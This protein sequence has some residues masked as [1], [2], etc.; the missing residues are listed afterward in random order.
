MAR[1]LF[2]SGLGYFCGWVRNLIYALLLLVLVPW[3]LWR[4]WTTG[5]YR[6]G[7]RDKLLGCDALRHRSNNSA[8]RVWLHGV[9]V[10]EIQ[11]LAPLI[12][13]LREEH[14]AIDFVVSTT[15][16]TGMELAQ[17]LFGELGDV[18]LIYFPLDFTWS[19][20]RTMRRVDADLLVLGELEVWPNLLQ[21]AQRHQ[22]LIV[23]VNGRLSAR[24]FRGY[25][26]LRWIVRPMFARLTCVL[27]QT[28]EYADRF[29]ACGVARD[30]VSVTGS[31]KFDHVR[32]D[33]NC[34]QV[35]QLA[36]LVGIRPE[37]CVWVLGSSQGPEESVCCAAW[38]K[39]RKNFP[40]LKL[41][42]VPRHRERF[43]EVF[44][45]LEQFRSSDPQTKVRVLRRSQISQPVRGDTWDVLLVDTIGE[46]RWWWGLARLALVGGS[47]GARNGQNMLEPAAYGANVAFGPKTLN[48]RSIVE[49]LLAAQAATQLESLEAIEA[50]LVWELT[51]PADGLARG[52]RA[53]S[54]ILQ[55]Q[56]AI[57]RTADAILNLL[58]KSEVCRQ[59]A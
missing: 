31:F 2:A 5:R 46:L 14:T 51:H 8:K 6:A 34:L 44:Q 26:K 28:Q 48:F 57:E 24:S 19:V 45:E 36:E 20:N 16:E 41:I 52:K 9:S 29:I 38:D 37:H 43:D 13:R 25:Q 18:Q 22:M 15:T 17:K 53:Q 55:H 12:E 11:L 42:V 59:A 4:S 47:F 40:H 35:R 7:L 32:F 49:L 23:V 21:A 27:A 56:G 30:R 50:W 54:L 33:A 10:G 39:A 1:R 3:L 58:P